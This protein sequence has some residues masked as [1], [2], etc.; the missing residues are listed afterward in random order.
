MSTVD[1]EYVNYINQKLIELQGYF[2]PDIKTHHYYFNSILEDAFFEAIKKEIS[3]IMRE[4][5]KKLED[6]EKCYYGA[7]AFKNVKLNNDDVLNVYLE[8]SG[9][10][11]NQSGFVDTS[12]IDVIIFKELPDFIL[13]K[14][15]DIKTLFTP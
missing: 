11:I 3:S 15:N 4:K 10:T 13:D 8:F 1:Y 14:Y 5:I 7:I 12:I 6:I 2:K 9:K